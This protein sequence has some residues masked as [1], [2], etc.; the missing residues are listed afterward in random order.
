[1]DSS[2]YMA[3]PY[4]QDQASQRWTRARA[5]VGFRRRFFK[6]SRKG[7][8]RCLGLSLEAPGREEGAWNIPWFF[9]LRMIKGI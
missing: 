5:R 6:L 8:A 1:M 2:F 3:K 9:A 7:F 4:P